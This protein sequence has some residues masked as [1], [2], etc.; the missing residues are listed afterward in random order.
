MSQSSGSRITR[1]SGGSVLTSWTLW[2]SS[3]GSRST[4][5][6]AVAAQEPVVARDPQVARFEVASSG[7]AGASS[8]SHRPSLET[9]VQE[10]RQFVSVEAEQAKFV[11]QGLQLSEFQTQELRI[12]LR[13]G[14]GLVVCDSERTNLRRCEAGSDMDG[15]LLETP[16]IA[17]LSRV[18]PT[19]PAPL[20]A[21]TNADTGSVWNEMLLRQG[22]RAACKRAG[23]IGL[24]GRGKLW[25][26]HTGKMPVPR[27]PRVAW[28]LVTRRSAGALP[29]NRT[30]LASGCLPARG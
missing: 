29:A 16:L 2:S 15:N 30:Y 19:L 17:A 27:R 5:L 8:G 23:S 6:G 14:G 9:A 25:H 20:A 28:A 3:G 11:V 4:D 12:P 22:T 7:G 24:C 1:S 21:S 26:S 13:D 10:L 18:C